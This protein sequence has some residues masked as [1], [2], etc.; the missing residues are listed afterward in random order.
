[1][2]CFVPVLTFLSLTI[3]FAASDASGQLADNEILYAVESLGHTD[4][5]FS[6]RCRTTDRAAGLPRSSTRPCGGLLRP[7]VFLDT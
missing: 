6:Y 7:R 1:M 5:T 2:R 3:L 4:G